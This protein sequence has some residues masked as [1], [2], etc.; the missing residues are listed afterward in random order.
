MKFI[1]IRQSLATISCLCPTY[2]FIM[3][4]YLK[5]GIRKGEKTVLEYKNFELKKWI[6]EWNENKPNSLNSHFSRTCRGEFALSWF[7][8]SFANKRKQVS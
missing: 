2:E 7:V 4:S 3:R 1:L 5:V 6:I 8:V